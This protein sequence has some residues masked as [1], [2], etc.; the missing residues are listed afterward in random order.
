M[1]GTVEHDPSAT[2]VDADIAVARFNS[3]GTLDTT[4][5]TNGV[6]IVDITTGANDGSSDINDSLWNAAVDDQDRILLFGMAKAEARADRDRFVARL[7]SSGALDTTFNSTGKHVYGVDALDLNDNGRNGFVQP[8]KKIFHGGYT[9]VSG[10]NQIVLARFNE[11]GTLDTSF[12]SDG[13]LRSAPLPAPGMAEAYGAALQSSG[14]YVTTGYG[15]EQGSGTVDLVSFRY[16]SDGAADTTWAI[17]GGLIYDIA[18]DNDRGRNVI[19]LPGDRTLHVGSGSP[20]TGVIHAMILITT[21]EGAL[22]AS[23]DTDGVKLY[24][25]GSVDQALFGAAVSPDGKWVAGAG[26]LRVDSADDD[27]ALVLLP[28]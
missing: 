12:D 21:A 16:G 13:I 3:D 11:D 15:R 19:P 9:N 18:A 23:F 22:D 28:L 5:G 24:D 7:T 8:D 1:A 17:N 27:A 4:F 20:S 6:A 26:Y 2:Y 14:K 10:S 25:F